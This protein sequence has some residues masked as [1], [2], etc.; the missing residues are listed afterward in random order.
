MI[1]RTIP[2]F[3]IIMRCDRI[4][5]MEIKLPEGYAIRT[6]QPGDEDAWAALMCAVGEQTDLAEAKAEFTRRY[7]ADTALTDRIFFAVDANEAVVGTAIAWQDDPRGPGLRVLHWLAVHPA[8]QGKGLGRALC[9]TCL[10]LFRREDNA[11]PSSMKMILSI[12]SMVE[13]R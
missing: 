8:H 1:D 9:Q 5:P 2:Y 12:C 13:M 6:Y 7:L 11:A 10:R 3:N 4:L